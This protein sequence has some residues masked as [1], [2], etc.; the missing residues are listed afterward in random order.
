MPEYNARVSIIIPH[1]NGIDTL[2]E[3]LLS[4]F[5]IRHDS[6]EVIVVDN[7]STDGSQ[8][9]VKNTYPNLKLIEN[10]KNYGYAGGCNRGALEA[11][12]DYLVF[13]NN[14]TIQDPDWIQKLEKFMKKD[15]MIAAVQPK[16]L[17]YFNKN[18]FD[19]AGGSGGYMDWFCFPYARGRIFS[20]QERDTGQYNDSKQCF[21]SSGTAFMI[22]KKLFF[23]AGKFDEYFFSHMEEIDLCWRLQAMGFQIWVE[24]D[25]IVYHKNALSMPMHSHKKH[26]LNHRN[27]LLMLFGN[28]SFKNILILGSGRII[29]ELI[30]FGY[31][32]LKLDWKHASAIIRS[33]LYILFHVNLILKRRYNFKKIRKKE[34]KDIIKNIL[35]SSIVINYYLKRV[36]VYS[37][38]DSIES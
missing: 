4:L 38:M 37:E 32:I 12:G 10:E 35:R 7:A 34:D 18:I 27:S 11:N 28:Y 25:A 9:W 30:A 19:Y 16:V 26:Y 6:Y 13:L 15:N 33:L 3:C 14:D 21:W 22:R 17:N 8:S 24:P 2:S 31:S 36:Q 23:K 5:K 20:K 1:W 29:F